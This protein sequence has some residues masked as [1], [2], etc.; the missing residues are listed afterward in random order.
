MLEHLLS[1]FTSFFLFTH[2]FTDLFI[3]GEYVVLKP[4]ASSPQLEP[5]RGCLAS[6]RPCFSPIFP[7]RR[8]KS[9]LKAGPPRDALSSS[10]GVGLAHSAYAAW[11]RP[12][13]T[14]LRLV[15]FFF[16]V[17][18]DNCPDG[19]CEK[20]QVPLQSP[21]GRLL[22]RHARPLVTLSRSSELATARL[23]GF[24]EPDALRPRHL[25]GPSVAGAVP[26]AAAFG[27]YLSRRIFLVRFQKG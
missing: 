17:L 24:E 13:L 15:I 26:P 6:G 1:S 5:G 10:Q 4:R 12:R 25:P 22:R 8:G 27:G 20:H 16:F 9:D 21:F 18:T 23:V 19:Q 3:Q 2:L 11:S 7:L 14:S